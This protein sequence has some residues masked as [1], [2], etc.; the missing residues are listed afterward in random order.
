M[1]ALVVFIMIYKAPRVCLCENVGS[2]STLKATRTA[3]LLTLALCLLL[4]CSAAAVVI[5]LTLVWLSRYGLISLGMKKQACSLCLKHCVRLHGSGDGA[6]DAIP[7]LCPSFLKKIGADNTE[8]LHIPSSFVKSHSKKLGTSVTLEGPSTNR[9]TVAVEGSFSKC[10]INLGLGWVNFVKDHHLQ[11]GDQLS[12]T[13]LGESHF[14]VEIYDETGCQKLGALDATNPLKPEVDSN[15]TTQEANITFPECSKSLEQDVD[16][17]CSKGST[18]VASK[19]S[20]PSRPAGQKREENGDPVNEAP[21]SKRTLVSLSSDDESDHEGKSA[22]N[23]RTPGG[24]KPWTGTKRGRPSK[25]QN[26]YQDDDEDDFSLFHKP[27]SRNT[28]MRSAVVDADKKAKKTPEARREVPVVVPTTT[29]IYEKVG[30]G[31]CRYQ[32]TIDGA[33]EDHPHVYVD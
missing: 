15:G 18:P 16:K 2:S 6:K 17:S 31:K 21:L 26:F 1:L 10:A 13:L 25:S 14:S 8:M 27:R 9:W 3:R 11:P 32:F 24:E 23:K 28:P 7:S 30:H 33:L 4:V 20:T 12:F 29:S 19:G 22:V 5:Y